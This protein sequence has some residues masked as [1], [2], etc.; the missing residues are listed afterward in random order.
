M[1]QK[2]LLDSPASVTAKLINYTSSDKVGDIYRLQR[3][4]RQGTMEGKC[5]GLVTAYSPKQ[6]TPYRKSYVYKINISLEMVKKKK[7]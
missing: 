3:G 2:A 6:S 7:L 5:R 4:N 1:S